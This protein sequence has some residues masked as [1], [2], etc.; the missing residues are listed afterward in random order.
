MALGLQSLK[1]DGPRQDLVVR[2]SAG[3]GL[4]YAQSHQFV[5]GCGRVGKLLWRLR[6]VFLPCAIYITS[7]SFGL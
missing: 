3:G 2:L 4:H 7:S 6:R 1:T 5:L